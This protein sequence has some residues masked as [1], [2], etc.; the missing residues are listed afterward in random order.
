MSVY[1]LIFKE[2]PVR[3]WGLSP[4]QR[5]KRMLEH[6][7]VTNVVEDIRAVPPEGSVL[8]LRGDYLYDDRVINAM[9]ETSNVLLMDPSGQRPV[10]VAAHVPSS[11]ALK[12][13]EALSGP[14]FTS[15]IP[16][17]R[18]ES[19][20]TLC[21]SYQRKLRK[22]DPPFVLPATAQDRRTLENRLFA[23]AYKGVTDLVTKWVWPHPAKWATRLCVHYGLLP[24]HVTWTS[25]LLVMVAGV[26]FFFGLYGWGLL[27]GWLMTFLDTVD[28]KLARVTVTSSRFGNVLDHGLDLIHPPL[29]YIVWGLGLE[30]FQPGIPGLSLC[31]LLWS[32]VL[33]YIGGRLVEGAFRWWLGNFGIFCWR[34]ID[35]YF[36]LITARRN[37][38]LI[39]LSIGAVLGRPDLGLVAVAFWTVL[40]TLFLVMRLSQALGTRIVSG[41]LDSWFSDVDLSTDNPSLS[42]KLFTN[43]TARRSVGIHG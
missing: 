24:N 42:V 2:T 19:P 18:S 33:G 4:R 20:Q 34:P 13:R 32:I 11:L 22:L 10:A 28:G 12:A 5:L 23:G 21:P 27:L 17:V 9:V 7:G 16:G 39:L 30:K 37:P 14:A 35:S 36:R 8:L 6:T 40:T 31:I 25:V 43:Y 29:W 41:P 26:L 1:V 38:N 3:L 15:V